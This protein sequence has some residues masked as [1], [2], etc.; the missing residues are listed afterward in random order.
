MNG[1]GNPVEYY[2]D[3]LFALV[4]VFVLLVVVLPIAVIWATL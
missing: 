1:D 2:K 3:R 4:L